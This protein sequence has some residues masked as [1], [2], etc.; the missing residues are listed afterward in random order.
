MRRLV[1]ISLGFLGCLDVT[2]PPRPPPPGPGTIQGNIVFAVPGRTGTRPATGAQVSLLGTTLS[3]TADAQTGRFTMSGITLSKGSL[4]FTADTDRDGVDDRQRVIELEDIGAGPG[5]QTALGDVLLSRNATL[6]GKVLLAENS[7]PI[8]H[9]GTRVFVPGAP[10]ATV[11]GDSGDFVLENLP[12]GPLQ[13]TFFQAGYTAEARSITVRGGEEARL[14]TVT[15]PVERSPSATPITVSAVVRIEGRPLPMARV[16]LVSPRVTVRTTTNEQGEFSV[17]ASTADVYQVGIEADGAVSL[18][19]YNVLLIPGAN[20][21]GPLELTAGLSLPLDLDAGVVELP[22]DGGTDAGAPD[23]G[24]LDGGGQ[25]TLVAVI[26]PPMLVA[27]GAIGTL[28]SGNSLGARPLT[29]RWRNA[30][31]GGLAL[32]FST[33]ETISPAVQFQAP[34]ASGRYPVALRVVEPAGRESPEVSAMV[35]VGRRPTLA[36]T[37]P[38]DAPSGA[39]ID[40]VV[41][42][43]STDDRPIAYYLWRQVTGPRV[44]LSVTAGGTQRIRAPVVT[45]ATP[46][47]FEVSAVTD[48]GLESAPAGLTLVVQ[49]LAL[50]SVAATATPSLVDFR[51]I[52]LLTPVRLV[53]AVVGGLPDASWDYEWSP[54]RAGCPL[55]DGGLTLACPEAWELTDPYSPITEFV[56]PATYGNTL[57]TFTL[58]ATLRDAGVTVSDTVQVTVRDVRPPQCQAR[59]SPLS[60][61]LR[62]D[63]P[64]DFSAVRFDAGSIS[65]LGS[66]DA[67]LTFDGGLAAW[68]FSQPLPDDSWFIGVESLT[69]RGG[70]PVPLPNQPLRPTFIETP[71]A[72]S[73]QTSTTPPRPS[74]VSL[75]QP[76][77]G[78]L[79]RFV[80]GRITDASTRDVWWM[81]PP[82]SCTTPCDIPTQKNPA[83]IPM[84]GVEPGPS[85]SV[86]STR[87]RAYVI[88]C[89]SNPNSL[90]EYRHGRW[91]EVHVM[92]SPPLLSLSSDG[93][94][95]WV[96]HG[97][98]GGLDRRRWVADSGVFTAP[99]VIVP[100]PTQ[101]SQAELRFHPDG[102]PF[103]VAMA[104][105]VYSYEPPPPT[106]PGQWVAPSFM[107]PSGPL[108]KVDSISFDGIHPMF[109]GIDT[110]SAQVLTVWRHDQVTGLA[111]EQLGTAGDFDVAR[112]GQLAIIVWTTTTGELRLSA[113]SSERGPA[114]SLLVP[115]GGTRWNGA[116]AASAPRLIIDGEELLLAWQE[117][118]A[119]AWHMVAKTL[120]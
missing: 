96:L 105:F 95:L 103:T 79:K 66:G 50:A 4:L 109:V 115:D 120:R 40:L 47:S 10:F 83:S 67:T 61:Q 74:W 87:K 20:E 25:L 100:A 88:V 80:V 5:K 90:F 62:C 54:T 17:Q 99:E 86:V 34:D 12:E 73:Q 108:M 114:R 59:L 33:T 27:P 51:A 72:R 106:T 112:L 3:A 36:V 78:S 11:T 68:R 13:L 81:T 24:S 97:Q 102:R 26:D 46:L 53:G 117:G 75:E 39:D 45:V 60:Y 43:Q 104:N 14:S 57:L 22:I 58:R 18:R 21:L 16:Q 1:V 85:T 48:I 76:E 44:A 30:G 77:P 31:D 55:E 65:G 2:I 116:A 7:R 84:F 93:D 41:Q 71:T 15:L 119:G 29:S 19:L 110:E 56:A 98:D 23:G 94:N 64:L 52:G 118:G 111:A 63:E 49:P 28:L 37:T 107:Y 89:Q 69:D 9:G 82:Q 6:A 91:E 32:S 70:N 113:V 42:G 35:T 8:G 38:A 101:Y 92:T